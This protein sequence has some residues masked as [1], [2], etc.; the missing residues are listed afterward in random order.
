MRPIKRTTTKWCLA[1]ML[2]LAS[3]G[4]FAMREFRVYPGMEEEADAPL[5]A[6]YQVPAEFVVGRLMYP[7]RSR[8]AFG[9]GSDWTKG[10]SS[11]T[12]DYPKGDR[13]FIAMLKRLSVIDVRSVEQPV[14]P[15]DGDDIFDWPFLLVSMPGSWD[16]TDAQAS[17]LRE[18]LLRGGYLLCDSFFGTNE[19]A[20]FEAGVKKIFPD[21]AIVDLPDDHPMFHTVYDLGVRKQVGNYRSMISRGVPYRD[22]GAI[23]HWRAV[24]DDE[25]RVM[26]AIA[27]NNDLGDS[28]QLAD[29]PEYPQEDSNLGL[30]MGVNYAVY[31]LTH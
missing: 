20:G 10:Q 27:F 29:E 28:W 2:L 12:V 31:A 24:L 23:P 19:W 22:D 14:N 13:T 6:D 26:I 11:W 9:G 18:Y 16:L 21:R 30:R 5:P 3:A 8:G 25:G 15:D 4:V 17:K 7:G 1:G